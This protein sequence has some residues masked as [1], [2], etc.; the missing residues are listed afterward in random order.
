MTAR[1]R[2]PRS[3]G[4]AETYLAEIAARLPGSSRDHPAIIAEL[5]AGLLD[6]VDA[7]RTR[8]LTAGEADRAAI[9][10]FGDPGQVAEAFGPEL[11]ARQAR[12]TALALLATGP[13]IGLLWA[14][15]ALASHLGVHRAPPWQWAG[16]LPA[17]RAAIP[18]TAAVL[19]VTIAATLTAIAATGPLARWLPARPGYAPAAAALAGTGA[20]TADAIIL[21]IL[22]AQLTT[23]PGRISP[24]P[25]TAAAAAS[26][27]RLA[28]A[29]R[30]ARRC[31]NTRDALT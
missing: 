7:H 25:V 17:S 3:A 29:S 13:L 16:L 6:T 15:T 2:P 8:G 11:A 10:E 24:L 22:T 26:L 5:R 23:A 9:A 30:A 21:A 31:R 28:L 19:V 4:L 1:T 14:A 18:L 27:T 12:R 20:T